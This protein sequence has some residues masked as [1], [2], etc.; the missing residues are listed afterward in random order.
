[1]IG[2]HSGAAGDWDSISLLEAYQE[3]AT[4]PAETHDSDHS[5]D[6]L[7]T[8]IWA[9]LLE[10]TPAINNTLA[11]E[12]DDAYD[13]P[14]YSSTSFPGQTG[15]SPGPWSAREVHLQGQ[16]QNSAMV[17]GFEVPCGLILCETKAAAANTIGLIIELA[18]GS[19]KGV[20]AEPMGTAKLDNEKT[21]RVS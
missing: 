21:W 17:G 3:I 19:Y 9:N 6:G 15:N 14:P 12:L 2:G 4:P 13:E 10:T 5:D 11:A 20:S 7:V 8:G 18:P 16:F 1:M